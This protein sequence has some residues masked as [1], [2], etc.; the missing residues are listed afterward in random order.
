MYYKNYNHI[1]I[2]AYIKSGRNKIDMLLVSML[3]CFLVSMLLCFLVS[4]IPCF[5]AS[6]LL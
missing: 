1:V 6:V 5:Y 2:Y 4:M 3:L